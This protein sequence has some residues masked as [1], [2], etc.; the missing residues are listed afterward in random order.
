MQDSGYQSSYLSVKPV[1]SATAAPVGLREAL[2]LEFPAID[3]GSGTIR[4]EAETTDAVDV[5][6]GEANHV[7]DLV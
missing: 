6:D 4:L 1:W 5:V 7:A 2:A 3:P